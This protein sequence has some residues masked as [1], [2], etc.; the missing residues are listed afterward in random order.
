MFSCEGV[1]SEL[2]CDSHLLVPTSCV[3]SFSTNCDGAMLM[4]DESMTVRVCT[5]KKAMV[6]TKAALEPVFLTHRQTLL[7][8][9]TAMLL[10]VA[11]Y[12]SPCFLWSSRIMLLV[13][14]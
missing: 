14:P 6:L 4:M 8:C 1:F 5:S 3:L 12:P 7:T 11:T 2:L 13:P 10:I 9:P